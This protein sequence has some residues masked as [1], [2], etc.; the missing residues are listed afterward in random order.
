MSKAETAFVLT[1][2][3]SGIGRHMAD[4]L[5]ARGHRVFATDI[6]V[7]VL[8]RHAG[9]QAWPADRTRV[10]RLDVRDAEAWDEVIRQAVE[11]FGH[12]DVLMNIAGYLRP[13]LVHETPHDEVHRQIDVN[14]KGVIFGTRAAARYMVQQRCGHIIN[15]GSFSS[16]APIPGIAV[17]CASKY[18]VRGFSL[19]AA[20]ELRSFGVYV[21]LVC[22]EVVRTPMLDLQ[23]DYPESAAVFSAPRFLSPEDVADVI[24]NRVLPHKPLE[25]FIPRVRGRL[26]RLLDA[27]PRLTRIAWPIL[28]KRGL[29]RQ[30][31]IRGS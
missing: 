5:V 9:S 21:S 20:Q 14:T 18:A 29:A 6:D 15:V 12:L 25:V 13:G 1:G 24:L 11:A 2:C 31:Q 19:A 27:F 26:L 30:R 22:P 10:C 28:R 4:V 7:D 17:Y 23:K 16:L 8:T 3:A